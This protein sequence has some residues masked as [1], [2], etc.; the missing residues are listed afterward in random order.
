MIDATRRQFL[1]G[2]AT[3]AIVAGLP[4]ISSPTFDLAREYGRGCRYP[5]SGLARDERKETENMVMERLKKD[6]TKILP[7]GTRYEIRAQYGMDFGRLSGLC[8]YYSPGMANAGP[9]LSVPESPNDDG[10]EFGY[11]LLARNVA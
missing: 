9:W 2:I 8:W 11:T 6:A 10:T 7:T 4:V 5:V 3:A 1:Q